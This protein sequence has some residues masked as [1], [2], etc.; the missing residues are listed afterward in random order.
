MVMGRPPG[1]D[2]KTISRPAQPALRAGLKLTKH[3]PKNF[4]SSARR[5]VSDVHQNL[6]YLAAPAAGQRPAAVTGRGCSAGRGR[7]VPT[8]VRD[9]GDL[10]VVGPVHVRILIVTARVET[11]PSVGTRAA[12]N[13]G[14]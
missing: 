12:P 6:G 5:L 4:A 3:P 10:V 13:A 8:V 7:L 14:Q 1:H 9:I 2:V 11:C